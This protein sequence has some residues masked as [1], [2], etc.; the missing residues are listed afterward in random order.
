MLDLE[1]VGSCS[2]EIE[3]PRTRRRARACNRSRERKR[4]C[5]TYT[6][7]I[8]DQS[9]LLS[10]R[11]FVRILGFELNHARSISNPDGIAYLLVRLAERKTPKELQN[12][13]YR[14]HAGL[15][16]HLPTMDVLLVDD[17]PLVHETLRA[18]VSK[19][20][21]GAEIHSRF[22]LDA[23]LA[24]AKELDALGLVLLDLGLPG[25]F[26]TQALLRFREELP[27]VPVV[28]ISADDDEKSV[29]AALELGA[30]GY[31]PKTMLPLA[32]AEALRTILDGGTVRP[33][34]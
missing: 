6:G 22:D 11:I 1:L 27:G 25:C 7:E 14:G 24:Q 16:Y 23:A 5:D 12:R 8:P 15:E 34:S 28:I 31:L 33:R 30:A 20:R 26:G 17:H 4:N 19:V 2:P 9:R 29:R 21:P 18:I 3:F 32:M 13:T 10:L